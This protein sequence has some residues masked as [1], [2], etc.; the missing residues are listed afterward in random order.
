MYNRSIEKELKEVAKQYPVVTITGPRQSG[1]TTLVKELFPKKAYVNLEALDT[2]AFAETDPRGFLNQFPKGAIFDEIQQVPELLSYIQVDVDQIK[3]AG[4]FILTGSHQ[5]ALH[6]AISQSLAGRTAILNLL[7]LTIPELVSA[8]FNFTLDEYLL[9]GFFPRI[10]ADKLDPTKAYRNYMQTYIERDVRQMHH[11]RDLKTFQNF[12]KLCAGRIGSVLNKESLGND[13]GI[14]GIT[15]NQ[16]LSVL[17]ASFIIFQLPP[18][19]ENFGKRVI[20]ASKLYFTDVGLAAYL[21]GIENLGQLSRDPLR[22]FLVENL[23]VLELMKAR[24]NKG[25]EPQLYYYRDNH[26]NEVDVIFKQAQHLIPIEIKASQTFNPAF[27]KN[28]HFYQK[29]VGTRAP[30]GFLIYTGE[31]QQRVGELEVLSFKNAGRIVENFR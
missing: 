11:I 20:K 19:F 7:P 25:L 18:Y 30:R 29:L 15:V 13:A 27:L 24:L 21:L 17:E 22:G 4:R 8:G 5:L 14:S 2:R 26:Q 31:H 28:L 16:W 3:Q 12:L 6:E 23:V 1:K 9:N 10:Y